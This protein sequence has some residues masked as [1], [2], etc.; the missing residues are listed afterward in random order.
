MRE[1]NLAIRP[2]F[3]INIPNTRKGSILYHSHCP[4]TSS[5]L[6]AGA[7]GSGTVA[8]NQETSKNATKYNFCQIYLERIYFFLI[9]AHKEC[10]TQN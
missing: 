4:V 1:L 3:W 9:F 10:F 2:K 6:L 5:A 8:P 7:E